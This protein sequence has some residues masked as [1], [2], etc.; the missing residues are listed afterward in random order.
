[1]L[2]ERLTKKWLWSLP[3]GCFIISNCGHPNGSPI[4]AEQLMPL[5]ERE[6]QWGRIKGKHLDG[7]LFEVYDNARAFENYMARWK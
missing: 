5:A 3:E 7:T 4:F 2:R 1:M 6:E